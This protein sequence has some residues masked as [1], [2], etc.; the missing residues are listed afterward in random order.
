VPK[1][2]PPIS[3]GYRFGG[4]AAFE[5]WLPPSALTSK[6]SRRQANIPPDPDEK[7]G[8]NLAAFND[9][10]GRVKGIGQPAPETQ[11][12]SPGRAAVI[13]KIQELQQQEPNYRRVT[14]LDTPQRKIELAP[15]QYGVFLVE[16]NKSL[17][18]IRVSRSYRN[19]AQAK[20]AYRSG[21][22]WMKTFDLKET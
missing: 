10:Y 17:N 15:W 20:Q 8:E 3:S 16:K 11:G 19:S 6:I 1:D 14:L 13:Q 4:R 9:Y 7:P 12:V 2:G 22:F 18:L 21:I 5:S